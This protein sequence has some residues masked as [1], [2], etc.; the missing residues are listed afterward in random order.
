MDLRIESPELIAGLSRALDLTEGEPMGHSIRSCWIGMKIAERLGIEGD[1]ADDLYYALL[2]KDA[3]CS[4]NAAQVS[5][6]FGTDDHTA[7]MDLKKTNWSRMHEAV[8]YAI[9][10]AAPHQPFSRRL[11]QMIR[12]SGRGISGARELVEVRCTRGA[13]IVR[14]LGWSGSVPDAVLNLDEHWDGQGYP[15]G[16]RGEE[17]P[18]MARMMLLS[19]TA[20]IFWRQDGP[21]GV[22]RIV[23]ERKGTWF[24]PD[25]ADVFLSIA[26]E[27]GFF[28]TLSSIDGPQAVRQYFPKM[29]QGF[30]NVSDVL[31]TAEI[32]GQIVDAK[33]PWTRLHSI[34]TAHYAKNIAKAL[35]QS[36]D[37]ANLIM[38]AGFF[39]DLGKLGVSNLILDKPGRL[40]DSERQAMQRHP[41]LTYQVLE[42]LQALQEVAYGASGHHERLDGSGYHRQLR[43]SDVP[44][45]SQIV[46]VADVFDA[47]TADRPYRPG[48]SPE[49][50]YAIMR[51]D[52]GTRLNG[53]AL[54]A[55]LG[56]DY[57]EGI[58]EE[59]TPGV[60][61]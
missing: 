42:P 6:W 3:G 15:R 60:G 18:F 19:Q 61:S 40:D 28:H 38:L 46:A 24:D 29:A 59:L 16:A 44:L 52:Q 12:L 4:A 30:Q 27:P 43:G 7:K 54:E 56:M 1:L 21:D 36:E 51:L 34:R 48:M 45:S 47:L 32:F 13:A 57:A 39:H 23:S 11:H 8:L 31:H 25:L 33:S 20:E 22:R 2:L 37:A 53:E 58:P 41:D 14:S 55:L 17:I 49:E 9:R 10:H 35:G 26:Q 50:A 5:S